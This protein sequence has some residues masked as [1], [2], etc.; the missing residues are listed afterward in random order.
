VHA[1]RDV[2]KGTLR[3]ILRD[4]DLTVTDLRNLL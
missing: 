3:S 1:N 2:P 4:C